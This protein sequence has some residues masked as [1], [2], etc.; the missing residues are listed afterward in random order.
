M[1]AARNASSMAATEAVSLEDRNRELKELIQDLVIIWKFMTE[2]M[3]DARLIRRKLDNEM[4]T[5]ETQWKT[6]QSVWSLLRAAQKFQ[7]SAVQQMLDSYAKQYVNENYASAIAQ[8][9]HFR[10]QGSQLLADA[11][12]DRRTASRKAKD[13][14]TEYRRAKAVKATPG[15]PDVRVNAATPATVAGVRV[16]Q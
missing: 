6:S 13:M 10:T 1:L 4:K 11:M 2:T 12:L 5:V 9:K 3:A 16:Q 7:G 14:L 15:A 8:F